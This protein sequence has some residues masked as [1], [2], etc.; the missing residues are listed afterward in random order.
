M[1]SIV[2]KE[3]ESKI[4]K[5]FDT[6]VSVNISKPP[7]G[8]KADL[9]SNVA[10]SVARQTNKSQEK[11][12]EEISNIKSDKYTIS[13]LKGFI[14]L[15]LSDDFIK[16]YKKETYKPLK[17]KKIGVEYT[18]PNP[19]KVFHIGHLM[20][21]QIGE[22]FSKLLEYMGAKVIRINYQGDVGIHVAKAIW[23]M[24]KLKAPFNQEKLGK[25]Y[26]LG[27]REFD[28]NE[29]E[30]KE[31]N[32]KIYDKSDKEINNLYNIGKKISLNDFDRIY[33]MLGTKFNK[34]FFESEVADIGKKEVERGVKENIFKKDKGAVIYEDP[35]LHTRVF[36]NSQGFPTYETKEIG[37][38][39]KKEK[40]N[41]DKS[42][43]VTANEIREYSKVVQS[44]IS[45][46]FK[47]NKNKTKYIFHGLLKLKTGKMSSRYGDVVSADSLIDK[48]KDSIKE[49]TRDDKTAEKIALAAI[50]YSILKQKNGRDVVFDIENEIK[51]TGDTG[52]YLM[53]TYTRARKLVKKGSVMSLFSEI[54]PNK[55]LIVEMSLFNSV[56][57][58]CYRDES[59]H[60]L[61]EYLTNLSHIFNSWYE[62]E[63]ILGEKDS[64]SKVK[65]V[66]EFIKI[67]EEGL[68]IV[69]IDTLDE[70]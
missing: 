15:N 13:P 22:S 30:I 34:F 23:G 40:L 42:Y 10:F 48:T 59:T 33:K 39:L 62:K 46:L 63:R 24:K 31:I 32:K 18:D 29:K 49:K 56:I 5:L 64:N 65:L 12:A 66:R 45:K 6:E 8:I 27:S 69:N 19:F 60:H 47:Y 17:N 9:S 4:N 28:K 11:I 43:I 52:P 57:E 50:R 1:I 35:N 55:S 67:M 2:K 25:A 61:V 70:M 36:I 58:Q 68:R 54:Y 37:L 16:K 3:L 7:K 26:A 41:I 38:F 44:A 20:T 51:I 53:Y 14:N 21:N